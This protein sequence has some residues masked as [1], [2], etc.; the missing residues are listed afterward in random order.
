[1]R[2]LNDKFDQMIAEEKR[3]LAI[4][5]ANSQRTGVVLVSIDLAGASLILLLMVPLVREG[6]QLET[7]L[8]ASKAAN[9]SL[10]AAVAERTEHLLAAHEH[11]GCLDLRTNAARCD[12]DGEP[13]G[14]RTTVTTA[15]HRL[16]HG[17]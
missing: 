3:L 5:T 1:M 4:R 11:Q 16:H 14:N 2:Q 6:R 15:Q 12:N 8:N 10:E 17:R 7:W 13:A 9:E